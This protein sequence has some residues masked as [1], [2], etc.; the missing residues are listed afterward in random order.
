MQSADQSGQGAG[1]EAC[2]LVVFP[3]MEL[4]HVDE[5][6]T[7]NCRNDFIVNPRNVSRIELRA[8]PYSDFRSNHRAKPAGQHGDIYPGSDHRA[9]PAVN[10]ATS[11]L[12]PTTAEPT[13]QP[14]TE[15]HVSATPA[16][17][18][19]TVPTQVI[20][21]MHMLRDAS[22]RCLGR[23]MESWNPGDVPNDCGSP[24]GVSNSRRNCQ[25]TNLPAARRGTVRTVD[26]VCNEAWY[27]SIEAML[28]HF[29]RSVS[30]YI[31]KS[32]TVRSNISFVERAA[33]AG[34]VF[35]HVRDDAVINL[36]GGTAAGD[37]NGDGY[38]DIY[39]TNSVGPNSLYRNNGDGTFTDVAPAAGVADSDAKG[40]GVGWADY[41]NDGDLDLFVANFG[42]SKLFRNDGNDTFTDVTTAS[43]VTDPDAD[44]RTMGVAWGDYNA[45]GFLDLLIV[46]H[47]VEIGANS[48]WALPD[49]PARQGPWR[50]ITTMATVLSA[51]SPAY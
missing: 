40:Y 2:S 43:G 27:D 44:H 24:G 7:Q 46:R 25:V 34:I 48:R 50:C 36:G 14:T 38:L 15:P 9:K 31:P 4:R 45:D 5:F 18:A 12:A 22:V 11:I 20:P 42:A 47:L 51:M 13:T 39:L 23:Y 3:A 28:Q 10:T 41:D 30:D 26:F 35:E 37:Y 32:G 19:D 16:G 17:S 1:F 8:R 6:L 49:W 29:G 21:P 33:E